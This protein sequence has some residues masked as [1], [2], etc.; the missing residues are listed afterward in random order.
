M[1]AAAW[2]FKGLKNTYGMQSRVGIGAGLHF[3][4]AKTRPQM[5]PCLDGYKTPV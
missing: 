2:F 5:R 1:I 3:R 4:G